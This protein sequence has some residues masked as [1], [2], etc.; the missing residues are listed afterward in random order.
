MPRS[1]RPSRW[2]RRM[3]KWPMPP[4]SGVRCTRGS[5]LVRPSPCS[6][7]ASS[8]A[9]TISSRV[10]PSASMSGP[11]TNRNQ[12]P[13]GTRPP[14]VVL[15]PYSPAPCGFREMGGLG[16]KEMDH[17]LGVGLFGVFGGVGAVGQ[18]DSVTAGDRFQGL[19]VVAQEG[20]E[21]FFAGQ[22]DDFALFDAV[23]GPLGGA[24]EAYHLAALVVVH[25]DG[26]VAHHEHVIVHVP[27]RYDETVPGRR[28]P[29]HPGLPQSPGLLD[30]DHPSIL[31][32]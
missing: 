12:I 25:L 23:Q 1:P 10:S 11:D 20:S 30:R 28:G 7:I 22:P 9:S 8:T 14:S 5:K 26:H 32:T 4:L 3:L 17:C 15:V 18:G 6:R 13:S 29:Q 21:L 27:V 2:P 16:T 24:V 31:P 19:E